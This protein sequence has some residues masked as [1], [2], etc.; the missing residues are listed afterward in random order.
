[1]DFSGMSLIKLK[2]EEMEAQVS[3]RCPVL[4]PSWLMVVILL[5]MMLCVLFPGCS[6]EGAATGEPVGAGAS[7]PGRAQEETLQHQ[8]LRS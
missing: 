2:M 7:A 4:C 6:G 3:H 5:L 1:M 8:R